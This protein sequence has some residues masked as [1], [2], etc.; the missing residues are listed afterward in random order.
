MAAVPVTV[1]SDFACPFSYVT[2][3]AL[4]RMEAADEVAVTHLAW[5]LYPSPAPLPA[6]DA[7]EWMDALRPLADELGLALR[8][9]APVRTR[10]AH[11]AAA[12]AAAKDA[13]PAMRE[14]LF[15]A[16]FAEGRDIGRID[17]LVEIG[18][19][20][21]L[22]TSELKVVLDVDGFSARI[23]AEAE[24]GRGAGVEGVP[25]VV[26]GTGDE[27]RWLVGARPFAE[28]RAAIAGAE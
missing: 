15:A 27:A 10:K 12:F 18:S 19:G 9:P 28:W 6:T 24:A 23:A 3:A 20:V 22:D 1:F 5:E 17:V 2:E 16:H 14:A 11:E 13:G 26:V 21:G 4:R 8:V 7:G 25:T